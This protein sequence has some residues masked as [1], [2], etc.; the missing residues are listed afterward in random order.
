MTE[1]AAVVQFGRLG[2]VGLP[3]VP[4]ERLD[5]YLDAAAACFARFGV[6]RTRVPDVAAEA[7]V[8]RVTVYR[9]VGTVEDMGRLL[10]ARDLHRLLVSVPTALVGH[11]GP[12][13]VIALIEAIVQSAR[14]HPVLAK[15]LA[16]EP[17]VI[18]PLL[19]SDLGNVAS[20]VADVVAPLLET[21]MSLGQ[22]A[23]RDPRILAEW[24]VRQ[25]VT[26]VIAPP[27]GDLG[28]FLRELLIPAL[29]REATQ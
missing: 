23:A 8:S 25:T 13:A 19:V 4:P 22:L 2:I 24:L 15:V 12:E 21:L 3:D 9:Q 16:D 5:P 28:D 10:L 20:R 17:Q 14:V 7:G 11:D 6:T 18:G 26:L 27:D 29:S 1:S